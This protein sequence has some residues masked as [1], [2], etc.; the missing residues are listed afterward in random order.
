M[1]PMFR[2]F[3]GFQVAPIAPAGWRANCRPYRA[4]S[5]PA[6]SPSFTI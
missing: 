4:T 1:D 6:S 2:Y 3:L 5:S